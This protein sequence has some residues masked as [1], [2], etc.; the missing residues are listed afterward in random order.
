MIVTSVTT[1]VVE[2]CD[3]VYAAV[4][5]AACTAPTD[6]AECRRNFAAPGWE[7]RK[8]HQMDLTIAAMRLIF[9]ALRGNHH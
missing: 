2:G 5:T 1:A 3:F 8:R 7:G 9:G 6:A 4:D